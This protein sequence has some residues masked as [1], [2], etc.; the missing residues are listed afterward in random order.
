M[1]IAEVEENLFAASDAKVQLSHFSVWLPRIL[2]SMLYMWT[3]L[4]DKEKSSLCSATWRNVQ[5]A[6]CGLL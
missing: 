3:L 6:L 1:D 4:I 2:S 5:G